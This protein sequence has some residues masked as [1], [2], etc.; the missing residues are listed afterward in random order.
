M[1]FFDEGKKILDRRYN[2]IKDA[3]SSGHVDETKPVGEIV[4]IVE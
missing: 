3:I 1:L 2:E 4:I